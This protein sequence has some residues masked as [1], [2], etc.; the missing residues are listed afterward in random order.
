MTSPRVETHFKLVGS[1]DPQDLTT[2]LGVTP[3]AAAR[4]GE[5]AGP[6]LVTFE[7]DIWRLTLPT[8]DTFE[9]HHQVETMV[10]LLEGISNRLA[11]ARE[12]LQ[13]EAIMTLRI[14]ILTSPVVG[15]TPRCELSHDLMRRLSKLKV[16]LEIDLFPLDV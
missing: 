6:S 2:R 15:G 11:R 1:F 7:Q 10:E 9:A 13:L 8:E 4:K 16:D 5:R 14:Y 12:E 3:T